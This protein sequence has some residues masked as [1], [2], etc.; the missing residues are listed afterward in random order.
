MIDPDTFIARLWG[1]V[2]AGVGL[3]VVC[4]VVFLMLLLASV[5]IG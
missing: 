4:S 2:G 5:L 1:L 3:V